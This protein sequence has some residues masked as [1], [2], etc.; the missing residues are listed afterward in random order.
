MQQ[1]DPAAKIGVWAYYLFTLA[2]F[3]LALFYLIRGGFQH[4]ISMFALPIWM[5]YTAFT[6]IKSTADLI[7]PRR[8]VDN[9]TRMLPVGGRL[10][11][12]GSRPAAAGLHDP[13]GGPCEAG[14]ARDHHDGGPGLLSRPDKG[15]LSCP[16]SF[17]TGPCSARRGR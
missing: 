2:S 14:G 7:G 15:A 17:R 10:R 16:S 11:Q 4:N 13:G 6:L 8:R 1:H 5:G 12:A 3:L 9:F